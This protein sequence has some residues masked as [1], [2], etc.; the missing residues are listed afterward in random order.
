MFHENVATRSPSLHAE[1][2][3]RTAQPVDARGH[4]RVAGA[5]GARVGERDHLL[6]SVHPPQAVEDVLDRQWMVVLYEP[7]EHARSL[8]RF[9]RTS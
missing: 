3:E 6:A 9:P 7:L 4:L 1:R 8:S 5:L 2:P